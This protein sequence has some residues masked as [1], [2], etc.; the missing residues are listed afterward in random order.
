MLHPV[1]FRS[2]NNAQKTPCLLC[3]EKCKA[4]AVVDSEAIKQSA[5]IELIY[6]SPIR[7]Y[8]ATNGIQSVSHT[9]KQVRSMFFRGV[10]M[11]TMLIS[12][13]RQYKVTISGKKVKGSEHGDNCTYTGKFYS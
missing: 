9:H 13:A 4:A 2:E 8:E 7:G 11:S 6:G 5:K 10:Y 3:I 1:D 12:G